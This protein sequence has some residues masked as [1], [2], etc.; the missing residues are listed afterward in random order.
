MDHQALE[1]ILRKTFEDKVIS[2]SEK[3]ALLQI[4]NDLK[5]DMETQAFI[6]N[7]AFDIAREMA[8]TQIDRQTL[9]WLENV[10]KILDKASVTGQP[11]IAETYFSPG[12]ECVLKINELLRTAQHSID[13]CVFTITDN[14]ITKEIKAAAKNGCKVRIVTDDEKMLD[15][16]SD[17]DELLDA[18]IPLVYDRQRD[19]MHHK[20]AIFDEKVLLTGSYNWTLSAATG[21]HEN[22]LITN[23]ERLVKPFSQEFEKLWKL[24]Q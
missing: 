12:T 9:K 19:H 22:I 24:F 6:R 23:D 4:V 20:F 14:R 16:G 15:R 17:A 3:D 8:D 1:K 5:Y 11:S 2:R 13:I 21:N 18:G 7:R 10:I